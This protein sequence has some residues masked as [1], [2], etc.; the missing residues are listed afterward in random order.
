MLDLPKRLFWDTNMEN[1]DWDTHARFVIERV[2]QYG[3][4][5][6]WIAIKRH[7][8]LKKIKTELLQ[9]RYLDKKTLNFFSLYFNI[10]K[11]KFRCYNTHPSVK[12]LWD[13]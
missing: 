3:Y 12:A 6:D 11:T 2:V 13:Y 1:L 8:G 10:P 5:S 7:Y 9:S 4:I